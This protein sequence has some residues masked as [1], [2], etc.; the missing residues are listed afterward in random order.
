FAQVGTGDLFTHDE[1]GEIIETKSYGSGEEVKTYHGLEPRIG[2][3]YIL[4]AEDSLKASFGRNRQYLH[5]LSNSSSGTPIDLWIPSSNN[6]KP[7]IVDQ[8]AAGYYRNFND[9]IFEGSLELYYKDMQ[10]QVDYKTGAELIYN[11]NVE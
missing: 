4:N 1:N 8:Y 9:N 6:V 3:T 2:L 5:L 7:Q 11:E 10:N